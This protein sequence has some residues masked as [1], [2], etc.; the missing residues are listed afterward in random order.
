MMMNTQ[1]ASAHPTLSVRSQRTVVVVTN[2]ADER[3]LETVA[4]AGNYDVVVVES[5]A[6]AYSR[7]KRVAPGMV[8]VCLSTDDIEACQLLSMLQLDR[9]TS[10]IPVVTCLFEPVAA[11]SDV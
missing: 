6:R 1:V 9:D 3:V 4:D 5:T 8:I 11:H 2:H 10:T 7:I